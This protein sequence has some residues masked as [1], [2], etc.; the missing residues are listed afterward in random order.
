MPGPFVKKGTLSSSSQS[1]VAMYVDAINNPGFSGGPLYYFKDFPTKFDE[2]RLVGL[3]SKWRTE[4]EPVF[5]AE[6]NVTDLWT[7][8][9]PGL[10][11]AYRLRTDMPLL[12]PI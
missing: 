8:S 11:V 2:C 12:A 7:E 6:G 4:R 9:N 5:D 1:D 10:M 3:V